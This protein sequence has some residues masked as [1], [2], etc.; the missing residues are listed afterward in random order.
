[1]P[2]EKLTSSAHES[3]VA[4]TRI[5]RRQFLSAI[6]TLAAVT[7][8]GAILGDCAAH[9]S[10]APAATPTG[11]VSGTV[12][13]L[14]GV[15]QSVGR[16][17]LLE[18]SGLNLN[19]Y[20]DVDA[21][22][23][24]DFGAVD[25]GSYQLRFWGGNLAAVPEPMANPV[26]IAV[27]ANQPTVVRFQI[28]LGSEEEADREIYAGDNFFQE[29]PYGLPNAKVVVPLGTLVCWYN[30][31]KNTHSVSG[32]PWSDSGPLTRT[33]SF[34]WTA[35][36]VGTFPYRCSFHAPEMQATLQVTAG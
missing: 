16:I 25:V 15:A 5:D 13:D 22:G 19:Q 9:D 28:V 29:Q 14:Q 35:N 30:V 11:T 31:G 20:A 4:P 18:E 21:S 27:L 33:A 24:F 2:R 6:G 1:V 17:Y 10:T 34:M 23:K 26:R 7:G 12:T 36:Q 3:D 8:A 32:G